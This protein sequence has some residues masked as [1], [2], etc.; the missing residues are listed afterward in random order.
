MYRTS[1]ASRKE[2]WSRRLGVCQGRAVM[3]W[4][5]TATKRCR[6]SRTSRITEDGRY[7]TV[8]IVVRGAG[9]A[10]AA[11]VAGAS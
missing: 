10:A 11:A 4:K 1:L 8:V 2:A 7:T 9:A 6:S 5:P 3:G